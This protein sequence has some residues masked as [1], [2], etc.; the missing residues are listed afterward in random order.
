M[1]W[2]QPQEKSAVD[3]VWFRVIPPMSTPTLGF[4]HE[5]A[6]ATSACGSVQ[7]Q[8]W[9]MVNGHAIVNVCK[10]TVC[11]GDSHRLCA[12]HIVKAATRTACCSLM[13]LHDGLRICRLKI[14]PR[15]CAQTWISLP[16][17][18]GRGISAAWVNPAMNTNCLARSADCIRTICNKVQLTCTTFQPWHC[19]CHWQ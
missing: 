1:G 9:Q 14:S 18:S 12:V 15:Q 8:L 10:A 17:T 19:T 3:V 13:Q 2:A 6:V 5:D 11:R 7:Y 4:S 16:M